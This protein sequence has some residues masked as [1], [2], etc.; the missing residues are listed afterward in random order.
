MPCTGHSLNLVGKT[1]AE[2]CPAA[3]SFFSLLEE[4]YVFFTSSTHRY[5]I[6]TDK[7]SSSLTPLCI[8]KRLSETRWSCRADATRAF[9]L[10][11]DRIKYALAD[12]ADDDDEKAVVRSQA[13]GLYDRM[14]TLETGLYSVFWYDILERFDATSKTLQDPKLDIKTAVAAHIY[15]VE[16]RLF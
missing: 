9:S 7:L 1:A 3:V 5:Q 4:V 11:Y 6:L 15:S 14:S 13:E 12:I 8:P 16:T 2:C 10:G